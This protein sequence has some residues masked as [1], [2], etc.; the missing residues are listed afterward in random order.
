MK[1][2]PRRVVWSNTALDALDRS[3]AYLAERDS[4]AAQR[5]VA[6]IESMLTRLARRNSGRRGRVPGTYEKSLPKWRYVVAF[7]LRESDDGQG[8]LVVLHLVHTSRNWLGGGW[9]D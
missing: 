9:P 5:L 4:E 8:E 7:E 6:D 2:H 1:G 3:V